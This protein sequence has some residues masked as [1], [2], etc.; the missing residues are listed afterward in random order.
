MIEKE[1]DLVPFL[2]RKR[3]HVETAMKHLNHSPY[4]TTEGNKKEQFSKGFLHSQR[5]L[6][7]KFD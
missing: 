6:V 3:G 1:T 5:L 7:W 4:C 2:I